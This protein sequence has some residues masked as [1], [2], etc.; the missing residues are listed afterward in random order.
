MKSANCKLQTGRA[1]RGLYWDR[2][3]S[4]VDGCMPCDRECEHC[5]AAAAAAMRGFQHHPII[6]QRYA[7]LTSAGQFNGTIR[8]RGDLFE[9]PLRARKPGTW[10]VWTDLFH[11]QVPDA[12]LKRALATMAIAER[13]RFLICTKRP[14]LAAIW[15]LDPTLRTTDWLV[16]KWGRDVAWPP[17]TVA[18]G[19]TVGHQAAA[20]RIAELMQCPAALRFLSIEPLLESLS[21]RDALVPDSSA[22]VCRCGHGHG[23]SRCDNYGGIAAQCHVRGCG[24]RRFQ[25]VHG[26][27]WAVVGCESGPGRRPCPLTAVRGVVRQLRD[28]CVRIWIKQLDLGSRVVNRLADF[29]WDLRIRERPEWFFGPESS[30]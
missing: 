7:G 14:D 17:V 16:R 28:C 11:N 15:H 9:L 8:L 30:P 20:W 3:W 2:A 10:A 24:C 18:I 12:F 29:P 5:W 25:S 13:H 23:F 26:I 1:E 4:L 21:L 19:T 6:R 22:A 27:G